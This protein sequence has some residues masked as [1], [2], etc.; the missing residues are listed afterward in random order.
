MQRLY[1]VAIGLIMAFSSI[2]SLQCVNHNKNTARRYMAKGLPNKTS[3]KKHCLR[4]MGKNVRSLPVASKNQASAAQVIPEAGMPRQKPIAIVYNKNYDVGFWGLEKWHP[5]DGAKYSKVYAYLQSLVFGK[6]GMP[7]GRVTFHTPEKVTDQQLRLVHT[8]EYLKSLKSSAVVARITEVLPLR[9][10]PNFL[11]Q[12]KVLDPMRYA[13]GGTILGAQLALENGLAINLSGGYHHAKANSGEGFCVFADISI[14]MATLWQKNPTLKIMIIDLDAHQGNGHESIAKNDPRVTIFDI[15][16]KDVYPNDKAAQK[17][18]TFN[19]PV[20]SHINDAE[21]LELLHDELPK[22]L[23][24]AKPDL[25]IYNAGTDI[26]EDDPLG[27]MGVTAQGI[28]ERDSY[29]ITHARACGIPTLM[30][31]SGGYTKK[32]ADI[33]GKSIENIIKKNTAANKCIR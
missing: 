12:W 7:R 9:W 31:L 6:F 27:R 11:V 32:S 3:F 19:Y 25:I 5:F 21:Y 10:L 23:K 29:V 24:A 4:D 14:A 1:K 15:Y 30:V 33:I 20:R 26:Y 18:I 2:V 16:N 8:Q 28:I 22:A 13:T 17:Y